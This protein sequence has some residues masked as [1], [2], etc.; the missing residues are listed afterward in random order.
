MDYYIVRLLELEDGFSYQEFISILNDLDKDIINHKID[1]FN[2]EFMDTFMRF[3]RFINDIDG[4]C[5]TDFIMLF[6][7]KE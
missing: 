4:K 6:L 3:M 5:I 7:F 1:G 2:K